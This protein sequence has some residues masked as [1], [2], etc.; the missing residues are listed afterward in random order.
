MKYYK[1]FYYN[2][3]FQ[4]HEMDISLEMGDLQV[5]IPREVSLPLYELHERL[6]A[7]YQ[8]LRRNKQK[9]QAFCSDKLDESPAPALLAVSIELHHCFELLFQQP[10]S[11]KMILLNFNRQFELVD[12]QIDA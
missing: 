11:Q 8:W 10:S 4:W 12:F 3:D 1:R 9:I 2:A 6:L 5:F 7:I